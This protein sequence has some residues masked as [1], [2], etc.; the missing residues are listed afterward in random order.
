MHDYR[1]LS[2]ARPGGPVT[3][4][5]VAID[6][7]DIPWASKQTWAPDAAYIFKPDGKIR[8]IEPFNR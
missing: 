4:D 1:V 2:I 3:V 8:P 6:V 7:K 5:P